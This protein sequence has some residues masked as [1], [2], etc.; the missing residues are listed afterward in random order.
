MCVTGHELSGILGIFTGI[1]SSAVY[2]YESRLWS[3]SVSWRRCFPS[4]CIILQPSRLCGAAFCPHLQACWPNS[5]RKSAF[6]LTWYILKGMYLKPPSSVEYSI[7]FLFMAQ[8]WS[9]LS[10]TRQKKHKINFWTVPTQP[11]EQHIKNSHDFN[12]TFWVLREKVLYLLF[13][14]YYFIYFQKNQYRLFWDYHKI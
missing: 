8:N 3:S 7:S 4:W 13:I 14:Y 11:D 6:W 5:S 12:Q 1:F 10:V 9:N 2:N